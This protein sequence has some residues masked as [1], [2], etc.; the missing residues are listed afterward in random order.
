MV[1]AE[2]ERRRYRRYIFSTSDDNTGVFSLLNQ[3]SQYAFTAR[4]LNIS[5]GGIGLAMPKSYNRIRQG[6]LLLLCG[7]IGSCSLSFLSN[8]KMKIRWIQE[9]AGLQYSAFGCEFLNTGTSIRSRI[10]EMLES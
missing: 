5:E 8:V 10:R 2:H 6:D 3:D 9:A 7:V 1:S 4:I